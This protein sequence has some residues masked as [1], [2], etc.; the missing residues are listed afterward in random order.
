M[1]VWIDFANSPHPLLFAPLVRRLTERGDEVLLTTRDHAQTAELARERWSD[2]RLIGGPSPSGRARKAASIAARIRDLAGFARSA[3]PDVAVSHNSYAQIAAARLAGV[4][5]VTAMDFEHQPANNVAFRLAQTILL[6]DAIPAAAVRRQGATARKVRFYPS[7]KE[8]MYLGDFEPDPDVLDGL[9]I[10]RGPE[11]VVAVART[12][13]SRALYHRFEN[14]LFVD[15]LRTLAARPEVTVVVLARHPEQRE[16]LRAAGLER[17][18]VPDRVVDA[19]S[20]LYA[21]DLFIGAGGTMTR[22]AALMGIPTLT[23]FGGE[24]PAVD[25]WLVERGMLRRVDEPGDVAALGPRQEPPRT[26]GELRENAAAALGAF[27][28][29]IDEV[30]SRRGA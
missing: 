13:P 3:R 10:E 30:S 15:C 14:Q 22:E 2:V 7:L 23:V 24:R 1:R 16:E 21:A 25:E 6:P 29:A 20:L 4:P 12:S 28:A 18:I 26:P 17:T 5:A 8:S 11:S 27:E 9:G 19:R